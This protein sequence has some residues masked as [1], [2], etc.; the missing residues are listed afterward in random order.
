MAS[1]TKQRSIT[2]TPITTTRSRNDNN[3]D[4]KIISETT[5]IRYVSFDDLPPVEIIHPKIALY[6]YYNNKKVHITKTNR[7]IKS[8]G[9]ALW[10]TDVE[11]MRFREEYVSDANSRRWMK[12]Q[13]VKN[14][15]EVAWRSSPIFLARKNN[16]NV[17]S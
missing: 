15:I 11:I 9:N 1:S 16:K 10:Y 12:R 14:R 7:R 13:H 17:N 5:P 8:H 6:Y 3:S 4:N 2:D